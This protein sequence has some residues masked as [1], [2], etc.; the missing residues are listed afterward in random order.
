MNERE[1]SKFEELV[2]KGAHLA[3]QRL[4]R[5]RK[6]TNGELVFSRDGHVFRVKASELD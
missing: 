6:K 4:V 2:V 1:L 3:F 5:D